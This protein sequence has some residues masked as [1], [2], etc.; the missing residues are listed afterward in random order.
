MLCN[1]KDQDTVYI[2]GFTSI[3][4]RKIMCSN[5]GYTCL[6]NKKFYHFR[7]ERITLGHHIVKYN[8]CFFTDHYSDLLKTIQIVFNKKLRELYYKNQETIKNKILVKKTNVS[9]NFFFWITGFLLNKFEW[10][11]TNTR[12]SS[13][14]LAFRKENCILLFS[15]FDLVSDSNVEFFSFLDLY[16]SACTEEF[17]GKDIEIICQV[18]SYSRLNKKVQCVTK[19]IDNMTDVKDTIKFS[20]KNH[21]NGDNL[22]KFFKENYL[23]QL[24][25]VYSRYF[26]FYTS[27]KIFRSN[28]I[29][30]IKKR[31]VKEYVQ[32]KNKTYRF[33][34]NDVS[35]G[36]F[37]LK[38]KK[39]TNL[40]LKRLQDIII[41]LVFCEIKHIT[42]HLIVS[43]ERNS[44]LYIYKDFLLKLN[45]NFYW[46]CGGFKYGIQSCDLINQIENYFICV[47]NIEID[48]ILINIL[49][50][51]LELNLKPRMIKQ[52][53]LLFQEEIKLKIP[54][55]SCLGEL[56]FLTFG[57]KKMSDALYCQILKQVI[58]NFQLVK[59]I[60]LIGLDHFSF[61]IHDFLTNV[62]FFFLLI[63]DI[64]KPSLFI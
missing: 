56:K 10:L 48:L 28:I 33:L 32:N 42:E 41:I 53:K 49:K 2:E 39:Y 31:I 64:N 6:Y 18:L 21:K 1:T 25:K 36:S 19:Y 17:I 9:V 12:L 38:S 44:K 60:N 27:M 20:K 50:I 14:Y 23:S 61:F 55:N 59:Y 13:C 45:V 37:Y 52:R 63:K 22:R 51:T 35:C 58:L 5:K 4:G 16:F 43:K 40:P 54:I 8:I 34:N 7:L 47:R 29:V 62:K 24:K 26:L 57:N 30:N 15:I 46:R 11:F 3:F